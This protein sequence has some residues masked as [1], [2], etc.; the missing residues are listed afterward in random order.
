MTRTDYRHQARNVLQDLSDQM[1][2]TKLSTKKK[3][4]FF[5]RCLMLLLGTSAMAQEKNLKFEHLGIRE[6]LSHSNVRGILQDHE[7][8][9][10]FST[11]D[12]LNK[13]D[14]YKFTVYKNLP[15]DEKSLSHNNL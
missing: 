2:T 14:G 4:I 11:H 15:N 6:G 8:F 7:G 5:I 12:G 9:M 13:Y 3:F 1:F 10:W